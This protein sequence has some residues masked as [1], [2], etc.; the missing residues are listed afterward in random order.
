MTSKSATIRT[1]FGGGQRR[2]GEGISDPNLR[3]PLKSSY[4]MKNLEKI[5]EV[6]NFSRRFSM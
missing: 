6:N 2:T 1:G 3:V 5:L 4:L